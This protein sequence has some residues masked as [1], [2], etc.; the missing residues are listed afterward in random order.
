MY[1]RSNLGGECLIQ[2]DPLTFITLTPLAVGLALLILPYLA[3][4]SMADF[5]RKISRSLSMG[6]AL[7]IFAITTA[8]FLGQ[9]GNIDWL[10]ITQGKNVFQ[11]DSVVLLESIGVDG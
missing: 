5:T 4:A 10:N 2:S 9:I 7:A 11:N 8:L 3:P 1:I 6:V